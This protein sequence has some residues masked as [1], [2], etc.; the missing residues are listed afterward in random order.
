MQIDDQ[1]DGDVLYDILDKESE[2]IENFKY[3]EWATEEVLKAL[4]QI[5]LIKFQVFGHFESMLKL[6]FG[7]FLNEITEKITKVLNENS[8][9]DEVKKLN[10]YSSVSVSLKKHQFNELNNHAH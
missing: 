10:V 1:M 4:E 9:K 6:R 5:H 3:P 8:K 7:L 2:M